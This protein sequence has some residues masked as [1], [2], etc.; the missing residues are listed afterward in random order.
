[1]L[2]GLGAVGLSAVAL[3]LLRRPA[4]ASQASYFTWGGYD[5]PELFGP[6]IDKHGAPPEFPVFAD[7][8]EAFQK[9]RA[10]FI[11]D[12]IHPCSGEIPRWRDAGL[13]QPIDTSRLKFWGG[14]FP[15]LK[16]LAGTQADGKQWFVPFDWGQTSITY[17]TDLVD[18]QGQEESWGLLWDERYA[19]KIAMIG[20]AEDAW[21]CAAIYAGVDFENVT[22]ADIK[23]VGD[24][25]RQ[26]RPLVR[27]YSSDLTSVE[28]ALASGEIVAAMT[29]NE[30]PINLMG[31]GVSVKFAN[32]KEGALTWCCGAAIHKDAPNP[33][34]AYEIIDSLIAPATGEYL[35]TEFGYG[36]SNLLS[37]DR[38]SEEQLAELGL[39]KEPMEVINRGIFYIPQTDEITTAINRDW[40]EIIAGF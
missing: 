32:P 11:V 12:V 15:K 29:W 19:G 3:P 10:G 28:Q 20:A 31:Q 14:V 8:E 6:Y 33:D 36:H 16:E 35:I 26:Q 18:L 34:L 38:V 21:W 1:M 30:S 22:E 2:Q 7:A 5:I 27:L 17:R 39:S 9:L 25:L 4:G 13:I 23:K 40:E 24:L 37:F